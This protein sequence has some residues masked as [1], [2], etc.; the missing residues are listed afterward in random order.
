MKKYHYSSFLIIL[1]ILLGFVSFAQPS[2]VIPVDTLAAR[3]AQS[4]K[5]KLNLSDEQARRITAATKKHHILAGS[6]RNYNKD[7]VVRRK[8]LKNELK[9]YRQTMNTILTNQQYAAYMGLRRQRQNAFLNYARQH[10]LTI[11]EIED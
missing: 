7:S 4:L 3:E 10:N 6:I 2:I 9:S 8:A 1:F 5:Q 11:H